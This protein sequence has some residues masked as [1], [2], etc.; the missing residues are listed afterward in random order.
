MMLPGK[1]KF[2][3]IIVIDD[4]QTILELL[5]ALFQQTNDILV[6]GTGKTGEDAVRLT[7]SLNPDLI[8]TDIRMPIMDG[9]QAT[10]QIMKEMPK[11]IVLMSSQLNTPD[12]DLTFA[13]M[14]AGALAAIGKPNLNDPA[15]C[16]S[17]IQLVRNMSSVPVLRHWGNT[18]KLSMSSL[19]MRHEPQRRLTKNLTN[20][21]TVDLNR[22][23]IIGIASS[24]G[25]PA[26]L[27]T[28]FKKLTPDFPI[29]ILVV[30]HMSPGFTPGL[31]EWL[32][33]QTKIKIKIAKIGDQPTPGTVLLAPDDHH[34]WINKKRTVELNKAAPVKGLRPSANFMLGSIGEA[35]L[36]RSCGIILTG[37]GDD[38]SDGVKIIREKGGITMAQDEDSCVVFG[39][40][41]EAI[42]RN[43]IDH[44]L[45]LHQVGSAFESILRNRS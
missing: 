16:E 1:N 43:L 30:Q 35:Y 21:N 42:S 39:M 36:S 44:V 7:K 41:R 38:G 12:T 4:S 26:A 11:P 33:T 29:P 27:A 25:G 2:I 5:V 20:P 28:I 10:K 8:L 23:D 34:M 40:P 45:N 32:S 3:K 31:Q 17:L 9:L 14:H 19:A 37:M 22:I 6:I 24:T 13:A 15:N 18:T